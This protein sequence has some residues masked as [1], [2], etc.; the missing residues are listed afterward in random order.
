MFGFADGGTPKA[1]GLKAYAN[2]IVS[3]PTIFPFASG[4]TFGLMGEAGAEAIMPLKR[5]KNNQ[6]G[7]SMEG[8]AVAAAPVNL[9][10]INQT[11]VKTKTSVTSS[12][13]PDGSTNLRMMIKEI[14]SGMTGLAAKGQSTLN[15][16]IEQRAGLATR[17][18]RT[19]Y[20]K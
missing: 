19:A 14:D 1:A 2:Q 3:K 5:M 18:A 4:G 6:L 20:F 10:V 16:S 9:Q 7:V 11:S 8:M 12:V 13:G 17:N 15:R